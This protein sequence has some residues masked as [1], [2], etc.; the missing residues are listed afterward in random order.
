MKTRCQVVTE[1]VLE[2]LATIQEPEGRFIPQLSAHAQEKLRAVIHR[3]LAR[4][5]VPHQQIE[6]R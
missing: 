1:A 3:A 4:T 5:A 2:A 6:E